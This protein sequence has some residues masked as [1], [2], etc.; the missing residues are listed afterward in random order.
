MAW[1][2]K[3]GGKTQAKEGKETQEG[4]ESQAVG[5]GE[6]FDQNAGSAQPAPGQEDKAQGQSK[7]TGTSGGLALGRQGGAP[8]YGALGRKDHFHRSALMEFAVDFQS[9]VMAL[10]QGFHQCKPQAGTL[11]V[12]GKG[13][14]DLAE[15]FQRHGYLLR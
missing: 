8:A 6:E 9:A 14:C 15:W 1:K 10:H 12:A 4:D 11:D 13:R 7:V 3:S 5:H 2:M